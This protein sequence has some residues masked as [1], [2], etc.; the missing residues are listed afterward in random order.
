MKTIEDR[1]GRR[2]EVVEHE[3][4][5]G[6]RFVVQSNGRLIA[7]ANLR[8]EADNILYLADLRISDRVILPAMF[9]FIFWSFP[10]AKYRTSNFQRRGIGSAMVEIIKGYA[11]GHGFRHIKGKVTPDDFAATPQLPDWY[12]RR[13]FVVSNGKDG[14]Q[15][16]LSMLI[17]SEAR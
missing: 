1:K 14:A 9:T 13:G 8:F 16:Q 7:Y 17:Q 15:H 5:G 4:S 12:R 6:T 2:Y 3:L 11:K 10:P